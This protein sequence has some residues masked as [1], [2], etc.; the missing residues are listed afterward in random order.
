MH[1]SLHSPGD[2]IAAVP[3]LLGFVPHRSLVLI[4]LDPSPSVPDTRHPADDDQSA[5]VR[6]V[7]RVDLPEAEDRRSMIAIANRLAHTATAINAA[8]A[9]AVLVDDRIQRDARP[10]RRLFQLATQLRRRL[11]ADDVAFPAAWAVRSFD[12]D[13]VWR[14]V[15]EPD[16]HGIVADPIAS[17]VAVA[18][19]WHAYPIRRS[20]AELTDLLTPDAPMCAHVERALPAVAARANQRL[21]RAI[22]IDNPDSFSRMTLWQLMRVIAGGFDDEPISAVGLAEV[23]VALRDSTVRDAMFAVA[24]GTH[25]EAAETLWSI[26]ARSLPDPDRAEAATLFAFSA[27]LRGDTTLAG[28]AL[29]TAL[30]SDPSHVM[31]RLL[32][33]ALHAVVPP[34][35]LLRI[36]REGSRGAEALGIDIGVSD[37]EPST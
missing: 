2:L 19:V 21:T 37:V 33:Q 7:A 20:R 22:E 17:P 16:H 15:F 12:G 10:D 34:N 35:R 4:M 14:S 11:R 31:A 8:A 18:K 25:A 13:T 9:I 23:A 6:L 1:V 3:A 30:A 29:D 32:D 26:L 5:I 28:I 36:A 27:Y 24:S